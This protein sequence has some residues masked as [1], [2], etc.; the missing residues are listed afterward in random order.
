VRPEGRVLQF[1]HSVGC[2]P[3]KEVGEKNDLFELVG[4]VRAPLR[5]TGLGKKAR[6]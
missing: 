6:S 1:C 2:L 3:E 4:N 5:M